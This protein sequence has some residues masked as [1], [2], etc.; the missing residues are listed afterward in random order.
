M[1]KQTGFTLI[2]VLVALAVASVALAGL[3]RVL[4]VSVQNQSGL[5]ERMVATWVAQDALL[6]EQLQ[7]NAESSREISQLGQAWRLEVKNEPTLVPEFQ[8]RYYQVFLVS[9]LPNDA[10]YAKASLATVVLT[11]GTAQ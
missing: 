4:G 5:Q 1:P 10:K 9:E 6:S 8:Q 3:T 2:E 11:T 7:P